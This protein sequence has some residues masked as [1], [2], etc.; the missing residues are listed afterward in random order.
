MEE[1]GGE[2]GVL[3]WDGYGTDGGLEFGV[4]LIPPR[5]GTADFTRVQGKAW[6]KS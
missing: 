4:W 3:V 5:D 1:G 6:T 2:G